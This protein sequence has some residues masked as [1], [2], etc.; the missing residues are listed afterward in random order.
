M[1]SNERLQAILGAMLDAAGEQPPE[2]LEELADL[3]NAPEADTD[4]AEDGAPFTYPGAAERVA[5]YQRDYIR[6][7]LNEGGL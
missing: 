1:P 2:L 4:A 7:R 5:Q 6:A 3:A